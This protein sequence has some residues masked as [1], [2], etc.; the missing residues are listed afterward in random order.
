M[1]W[2]EWIS[3]PDLLDTTVLAKVD[4]GARTSAIHATHISPVQVDGQRM[5]RF[6]LYSDHANDEDRRFFTFPIV[7]ERDVTNSGGQTE[8]R[9][10]IATRLMFGGLD[11]MAELTLTDRSTMKYAMLLGRTAIRKLAVVDP[12]RS[13][14]LGKHPQ[15][16]IVR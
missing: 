11:I 13:Y 5:V 8:E 1:G 2:R 16:I 6:A 7:D 12:A 3:L 15:G 4:T 14:L 9:F 10:V